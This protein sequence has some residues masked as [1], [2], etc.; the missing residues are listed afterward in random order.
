[1]GIWDGWEGAIGPA[2]AL[3]IVYVVYLKFQDLDMRPRKIE[4]DSKVREFDAEARLEELKL[5]R[6]MIDF[7]KERLSL[8]KKPVDAEYHVLEDKRDEQ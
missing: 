2:L 5:K 1:M 8:E 7:E 4:A 3:I 6:D